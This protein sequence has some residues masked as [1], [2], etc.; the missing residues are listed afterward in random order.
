MSDQAP[1]GTVGWLDITV[2]DAT[3]LRDFYADVVGWTFQGHSMGDYEDYVM[4]AGDTAVGGIC[5]KRGGNAQMPGQW[6]VY[7]TVPDL[8]A[9]VKKAEARGAKILDGPRAVGG[10]GKF[11]ALQDPSGAAFA[12][13]QAN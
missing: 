3:N 1:L 7:I 8:D 12:L 5:H 13:Y 6:L 11:C 2:D 10:Q 9:A 4:M